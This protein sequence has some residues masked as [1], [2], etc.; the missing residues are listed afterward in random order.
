MNFSRV[1]RSHRPTRAAELL[2]LYLPD[3]FVC[4]PPWAGTAGTARLD[5]VGAQVVG[6]P[7]Q[8]TVANKWVLG[9]VTGKKL[10]GKDRR[11]KGINT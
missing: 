4:E 5:R 3:A 11:R 2:A 1:T 6:Q 9:Q 7:L 8:I 10:R